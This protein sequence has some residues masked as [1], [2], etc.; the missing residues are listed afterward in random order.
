MATLQATTVASTTILPLLPTLVV[1]KNLQIISSFAVYT[2]KRPEYGVALRKTKR[3]AW[4]LG[5]LEDA[6]AFDKWSRSSAFFASD[7]GSTRETC[8]GSV[9]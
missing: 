7:Q 1:S 9:V 4:L 5:T 2:T 8:I 3:I 6:I